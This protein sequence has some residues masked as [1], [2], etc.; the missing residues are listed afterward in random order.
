M[1]QAGAIH[2]TSSPYCSNVV[3]CRKSDGA[4]RLRK[5]E[6]RAIRDAYIHFPGKTTYW[7]DW[8]VPNTLAK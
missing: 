5:L 7:I 6:N 2:R 4:L 8:Y 3:F 1:L